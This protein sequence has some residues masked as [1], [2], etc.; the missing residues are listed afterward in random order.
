[1]NTSARSAT[2]V[3]HPIDTVKLRIQ[4]QGLAN[5]SNATNGSVRV[6]TAPQLGLLGSFRH[7]VLTEGPIGLYAGLSPALLRALTY[8]STRL[9]LYDPLRS[10]FAS[11]SASMHGASD[12]G[13]PSFA[14]KFA[15]SLT[16]GVVGAIVGNPS[17][18]IKVRMQRADNHAYRGLPDAL[19]RIV[20]DEGVF[21]LWKGT[22]PS[23][24]RAAVHSSTQLATYDH[25]KT[26]LKEW[27]VAHEGLS[28]HVS[29]AMASGLV[30][31]TVSTPVDV[32]KSMV[33][34]SRPTRTPL[35]C[36]WQLWSTEGLRGFMRGWTANYVRLGPNSLIMIVSFEHLRSVFGLSHL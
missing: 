14:V 9:G 10:A 21:A 17:D 35:D 32:I 1:M 11:A 20:L 28:M 7:V 8:T 13:A 2:T 24:L 33:M 36:M 12:V 23:A 22:Y 31:N 27:N 30:T 19:R 29:A 15:A 16:S 6:C 3:T 25:V 4:L 26:M 18:L 5:T 34:H